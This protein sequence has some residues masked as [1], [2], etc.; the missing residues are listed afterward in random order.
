MHTQGKKVNLTLI[1]FHKRRT[2]KC[3]LKFFIH[4]PHH[5]C[6]RLH[7][8][9]MCIDEMNKMNEGEEKSSEAKEKDVLLC[10]SSCSIAM[11]WRWRWKKT[12]GN[13]QW[14]LKILFAKTARCWSRQR[15]EDI[16]EWRKNASR[17]IVRRCGSNTKEHTWYVCEDTVN[18]T[19][20][21]SSRL[22]PLT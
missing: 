6:R 2:S 11:M 12:F 5:R 19:E 21:K 17:C 10:H 15:N 4:R 8:A 22:F 1:P 3:N 7:F 16:W 13:V 18:M 20:N 9:Y 14:K